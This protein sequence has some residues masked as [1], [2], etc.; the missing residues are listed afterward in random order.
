VTRDHSLT[1]SS[2]SRTTAYP[3]PSSGVQ[4]TLQLIDRPIRLIAAT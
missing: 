2:I 4:V 3:M 1:I